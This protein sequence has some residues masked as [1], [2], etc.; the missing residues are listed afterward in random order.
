MRERRKAYAAHLAENKCLGRNTPFNEK[1]F[2]KLRPVPS[3]GDPDVAIGFSGQPKYTLGW[4]HYQ[5]I[6]YMDVG[7]GRLHSP[8]NVFHIGTLDA[9][10]HC[11]GMETFIVDVESKMGWTPILTDAKKRN[12]PLDY[13]GTRTIKDDHK[14]SDLALA[15]V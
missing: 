1:E 8:F 13:P 12:P 5:P 10:H 9:D 3:D 15:Q 4:E 7:G 14:G 11:H 2:L 6:W